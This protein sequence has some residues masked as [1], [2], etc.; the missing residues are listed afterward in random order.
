MGCMRG[1]WIANLTAFVHAR[2]KPPYISPVSP[3]YLPYKIS[4]TAFVHAR[5]KPPYISPVSPLYLPCI[6]PVSPVHARRKLPR[7]AHASVGG[8]FI[9]S[10][11][12][13]N[14]TGTAVSR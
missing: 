4:L 12:C 8:H 2:R 1:K 5:R 6:S 9:V 3:L 14:A 10:H 13:A 7:C 11:L